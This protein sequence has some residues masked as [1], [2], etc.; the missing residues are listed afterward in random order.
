VIGY[1]KYMH[2]HHPVQIVVRGSHAGHALS[3]LPAALHA[4]LP[5]SGAT[6]IGAH[7]YQVR[8]FTR[9]TFGGETLRIYV[10]A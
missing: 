8:S 9:P 5:A 1:I 4:A 7:R 2:R 10:L 6:T 3:S